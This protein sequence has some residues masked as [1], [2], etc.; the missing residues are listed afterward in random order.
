MTNKTIFYLAF[1]I[2]ITF[3]KVHG[4]TRF[5]KSDEFTI[6]GKTKHKGANFH[7]IDTTQHQ[8]LPKNIKNL[9]TNGAGLYIAFKTNS[10]QISVKWCT[11]SSKTYPNLS[12]IAFEGLDLYIKQDGQWLYAGVGRPTGTKDDCQTATL[13]QDMGINEKECLLYLPLYDEILDLEIGIDNHAT[14][15]KFE[16]AKSS[17]K[18]VIYG[19][20]ITQ[21]ASASRPG[22]SYPARIARGL[23]VEIFNWGVS[24][25]AKM[26]KSV[27]RLIGETQMDLLILDCIANC[28]ADH[29]EERTKDF[30]K[31]IRHKHPQLPI[32]A[33]SGVV[34]EAGNFNL[35]IAADIRQRNHNFENHIQAL[36]L[37]DKNLYWLDSE[38]FLGSDHEGTID[39][40]HP[41]DIGFDR[42][43]QKIQPY[44][45]NI[46]K[47]RGLL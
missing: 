28:S 35:K 1:F 7:R 22:L 27:S 30:I 23:D 14:F 20:S 31:E 11:S 16:N 18:I 47:D 3:Q 2:L 45:E 37:Q 36:Q 44:L 13:V 42:M 4:Q 33:I 19:T 41:N 40:T 5:I 25:S 39:G 8:D 9:M 43:I 32:L 24:G 6:Q 26:E 21:G 12:A 38:G 17:P 10:Q 29:I 46:L 15:E 34:F